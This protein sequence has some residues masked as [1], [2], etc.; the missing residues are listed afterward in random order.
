MPSQTDRDENFKL[1]YIKQRNLWRDA[2]RK[3]NL[4]SN[5]NEEYI[6]G[7]LAYRDLIECKN[8]ERLARARRLGLAPNLANSLA[9]A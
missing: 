3:L 9:A 1:G 2:K 5:D 8:T 4:M 6:K 7:A